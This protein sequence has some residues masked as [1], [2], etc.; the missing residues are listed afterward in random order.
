MH[1]DDAGVAHWPLTLGL[2]H[3]PVCD[4]GHTNRTFQKYIREASGH[5]FLADL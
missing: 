5:A 2:W 4:W 1:A 3:V